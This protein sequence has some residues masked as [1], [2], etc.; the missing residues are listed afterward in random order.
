[1]YPHPLFLTE[2]DIFCV[3]SVCN[4]TRRDTFLLTWSL[5]E[6]PTQW[7]VLLYSKG[8]KCKTNTHFSLSVYVQLT[9]QMSMYNTDHYHQLTFLNSYKTKRETKK[10]CN[11]IYCLFIFYFFFCFHLWTCIFTN[12]HCI[13]KESCEKVVVLWVYVSAFL[14]FF[15][16]IS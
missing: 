6:K 1:M 4:K 8:N 3:R 10:L 11:K 9:K 15:C 2:T 13:L 14:S 5:R 16:Q 12:S 7:N